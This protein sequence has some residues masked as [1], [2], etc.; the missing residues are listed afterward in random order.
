MPFMSKTPKENRKAR[1][2]CQ[3]AT[4]DWTVYSQFST[5]VCLNFPCDHREGVHIH[6]RKQQPHACELLDD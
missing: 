3:E 2:C 1:L 6:A 5:S 4:M